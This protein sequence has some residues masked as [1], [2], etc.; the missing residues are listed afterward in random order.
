MSQYPTPSNQPYE[1]GYEAG[2]GSATMVRFFN[3]VYAWM[4]VGLTTTALVAWWVSAQPQLMQTIFRGPT[5]IILIL[6]ELALV[7]VIG[8][9][10]NKVNA[11]AATALFVLYSA[12]N[13][14]TLSAIFIIYA[15]ATL[16]N[17]FLITAGTFAAVSIYGFVT[18][19]DLTG[20]RSFLMMGLIGLIIA[21]VVNIFL[22]N[23]ALNAIINYIGVFL[24]IGLTAYDTQKL[25]AYAYATENNAAMAARLSIVGALTLYLDF[26]NLFIFILRIMGDRK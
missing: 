13:G 7:V 23:S 3:A 24:F 21:S 18:K 16:T 11:T 9:A 22:A 12:L 20:L 17:A 6:A 19:A 10:I 4:A 1:L 26:I 2:A 8:N 25:K 5:L 14:L 15:N